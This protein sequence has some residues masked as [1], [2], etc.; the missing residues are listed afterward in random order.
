MKVFDKKD[1][2]R[3]TTLL[4]AHGRKKLPLNLGKIN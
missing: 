2:P 1:W 3:V 4:I